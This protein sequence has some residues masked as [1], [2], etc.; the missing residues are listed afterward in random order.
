L[1]QTLCRLADL[2]RTGA[3]EVVLQIRGARVSVVVVKDG[4]AVRAYVNACPHA[5]TPLNWQE[6]KF[7]DLGHTYLLCASHGAAFDIATGRC[8]RGPAQGKALTPV[9]VTLENDR[10]LADL[11]TIP[12]A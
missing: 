4:D 7:F 9:A 10:I 11:S 2:E 3:K 6:D 12:A 8:I 1:Q 5:R